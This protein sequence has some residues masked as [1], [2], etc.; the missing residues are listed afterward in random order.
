MDVAGTEFLVTGSTGFIGSAVAARLAAMGASVRGLS[1]DPQKAAASPYQV[2]VGDIRE[3]SSIRP[4]F[5]GIDIVVHSAA[6]VSERANPEDLHRVNVDGVKNVLAASRDAGVK[7]IVHVSSCAVYGSPQVFGVDERTPLKEAGSPYHVSKVQAERAIRAWVSRSDLELV[8][9]RPSQVYGPGS[10]PFTIRP[11]RA[12]LSGRMFL[13][14]GGRF[15]FKPVFIDNLVEGLIRCAT[16]P[17]AP[18][19]AFNLTD[20]Y[21]IPW[22]ILFGAYAHMAGVDRLPSLPYP[23]AWLLALAF[24]AQ[25]ALAGEPANINRRAIQSLR[26]MNSFSNRKAVTKLGWEPE[27]GLEGGLRRTEVWLREAGYLPPVA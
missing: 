24:E 10:E 17:E 5:E 12:I 1:R 23:A 6:L 26:S 22:R 2:Y 19:Q 18:S 9:A 16:H 21:S 14:D 4:A 27:V 7:R 13:I 15:L 8:I 25:A 11:M 20:G 3:L